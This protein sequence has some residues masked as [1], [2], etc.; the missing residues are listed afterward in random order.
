MTH[1]Y[2]SF[3][4]YHY[5]YHYSTTTLPLLSQQPRLPR[6]TVQLIIHR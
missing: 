6:Q 5:H 4:H 2:Y 1:D 3:Y